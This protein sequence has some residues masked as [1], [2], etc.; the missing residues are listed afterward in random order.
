MARTRLARTRPRAFWE[1][2]FNQ[3]FTVA[4]RLGTANA[5]CRRLAT[6]K[7]ADALP[8]PTAEGAEQALIEP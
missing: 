7:R 8:V 5:V 6:R 4:A 1:A 2:F 3:S